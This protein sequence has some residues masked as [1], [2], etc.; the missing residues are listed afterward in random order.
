MAQEIIIDID[1]NGGVTIEGKGFTGNECT[2]F[3]KEI[4]Q[5]MGEVTKRTLK[6]EHKL[7]HT[8]PRKAGA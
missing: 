3:T 1:Q 6:P 5:A 4:E 2:A 8:V 7:G